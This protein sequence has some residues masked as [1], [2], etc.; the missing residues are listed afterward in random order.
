M[1]FKGCLF[2][3]DGV[4]VDTASHHF[5][6]WRT[7][8]DELGVAFDESDNEKLKGV[9]RVDSLEFILQ[10]GNL[11]LD[12]NTK[13]RLMEKKNAHYLGLAAQ[14]QPSDALPGIVA[15]ID[16]LK[17]LGVKIG[18]G[19]SSKNAEQILSKL[20]LLDAFDTIV[21][22]NHLTLSKPDPEVFLMGANALGLLPEECLVL[23]DASAGVQA[24]ISGGFCVLGIGRKEELGQ[25]DAVVSGLGDLNW[26]EIQ[27]LLTHK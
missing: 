15:L 3:L 21:D 9:S 4:I 6:A 18:L 23:E 5:V 24:A 16:E 8:A 25:A 19:S 10:K 1:T 27:N 14:I 11:V 20:G 17:V 13:L 2:D 7:L 22:G 26:S 12:S